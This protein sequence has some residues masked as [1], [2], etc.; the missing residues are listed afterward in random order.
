M[1]SLRSFI[2]DGRIEMPIR[3][4]LE[5]RSRYRSRAE[6]TVEKLKSHDTILVNINSVAK[7][8][9][10]ANKG[11]DEEWGKL[12]DIAAIACPKPPFRQMWLEGKAERLH[13]GFFTWRGDEPEPKVS[14]V[15]WMHLHGNVIYLGEFAYGLNANGDINAITD[16]CLLDD[17]PSNAD[18]DDRFR[19]GFRITQ[20]WALHAFSRLNCH[21][22][23]LAPMRAGAPKFKGR[24]PHP[25][26]SVWHEIVVTSMTQ[27]RREEA[28][29]LPDGEKRE[30]R[31]HRVRGHYADYTKGKGLFG[32][33]KVRIWIEE[34]ETGNPEL[35]TVKSS[36]RLEKGR[37]E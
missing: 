18:T 25:P 24:D 15:A 17:K 21:N 14:V 9:D 36:Y 2:L 8:I 3:G 19:N 5:M 33:W 13:V 10:G 30:L 35:G 32:R 26:Y 6:F 11:A 7:D 20:L 28:D 34:H 23:K 27:L 16:A 37:K 4:P 31:F 1:A 12:S 22:V 29:S